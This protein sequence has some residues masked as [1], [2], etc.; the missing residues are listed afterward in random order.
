MNVDFI[1][2]DGNRNIV[3]NDDLNH[4]F[5]FWNYFLRNL[6]N[7]RIFFYVFESFNCNE[8]DNHTVFHLIF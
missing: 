5:L 2:Y 4:E 3:F 6:I 8:N 1:I 7:Y